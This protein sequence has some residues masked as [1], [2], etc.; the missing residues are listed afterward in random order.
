MLP[1][2]LEPLLLSALALGSWVGCAAAPPTAPPPPRAEPCA[3]GFRS[4]GNPRADLERLGALCGA[5]QGLSAVTE[6]LRARQAEH[7]PPAI[8]ALDVPSPGACYRV[9]AA[10]D[11][12]VQALGLALSGA[13]PGVVV[14]DAHG[15]RWA[16]LGPDGP[17]CFPEAGRYR[18][19][20]AVQRG[21]GWYALQIWGR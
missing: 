8:V 3:Q 7:E 12:N 5:A 18:L 1:R 17:L 11:R 10:A 19:E 13:A 15:E 9:L 21:A 14:A 2:R 20:I 4:S 6:P 16:V